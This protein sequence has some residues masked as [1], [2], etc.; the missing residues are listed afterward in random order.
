LRF[1]REGRWGPQERGDYKE[2]VRQR[3]TWSTNRGGK[4]TGKAT[5]N[6]EGG[7]LAEVETN[8]DCFP[9]LHSTWTE[10]KEVRLTGLPE[11]GVK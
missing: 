1:E 6:V 4:E 10:A 9:S 5:H 8:S 3:L 2:D 7:E 11:G